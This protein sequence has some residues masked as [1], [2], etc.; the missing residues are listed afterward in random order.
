MQFEHRSLHVA[1]ANI[2][3]IKPKLDKIKL[4]MSSSTKVDILGLCETFFDDKTD[5]D[6]LIQAS[7]LNVKTERCLS[8][9]HYIPKRP[10]IARG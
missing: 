6:T 3:H 5:D 10:Q 8:R 1:I 4:L 7:V 2:C 9:V